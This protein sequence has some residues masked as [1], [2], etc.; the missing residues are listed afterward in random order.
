[1]QLYILPFD[2]RAT[3]IRDL[4]GY[5]EPLSEKQ[6]S[7]VKNYK[8]IIWEAFVQVYKKQKDRKSLG[9]LIDEQFGLKI[10]RKAKK[11]GAVL[12]V[13]AEKSGQKVFDFE[14]GQK[15]GQRI[16]KIN[17]DYAKVLVRYNPKNKKDNKMQF[18]KLK[19]INDFCQKKKG[20]KNHSPRKG[21]HKKAG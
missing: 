7:D 10:I 21:R 9:I 15:F 8:S 16:L 2:H 3:F 5:E 4:F 6:I 18:R 20:C 14:Y 12:A 19:K 13:A 17:P 11:L 1:M